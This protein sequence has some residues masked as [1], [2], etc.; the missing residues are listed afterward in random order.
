MCCRARVVLSLLSHDDNLKVAIGLPVHSPDDS[1]TRLSREEAPVKSIHLLADGLPE[2]VLPVIAK[3]HKTG[4]TGPD[5]TNWSSADRKSTT[6]KNRWIFF[7]GN[8]SHCHSHLISF[9]LLLIPIS[10][11]ESC[12][13]SRG[14]LMGFLFPLARLVEFSYYRT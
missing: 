1:S 11:L 2:T 12:S 9:P 14:I 7:H 3:F 10:K 5:R 4:Q 6:V 8:R 13:H